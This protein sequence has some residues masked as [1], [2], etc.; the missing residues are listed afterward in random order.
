MQVQQGVILQLE[1]M[2]GGLTTNSNKIA[3]YEKLQKT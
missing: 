2:S 1:R 3:L